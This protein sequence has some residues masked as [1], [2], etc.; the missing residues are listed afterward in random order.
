MWVWVRE[1]EIEREREG[2]RG[3]EK[4]REGE[5]RGERERERERERKREMVDDARRRHRLACPNR[6][7]S[8]MRNTVQGYLAH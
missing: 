3:R 4:G 7:T 1:R 8:L 6:G 2:E 5:R